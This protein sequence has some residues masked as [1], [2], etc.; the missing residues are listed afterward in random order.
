MKTTPNVCGCSAESQIDSI[1]PMNETTNPA[2]GV[3]PAQC[4]RHAKR[5]ASTTPRVVG[6]WMNFADLHREPFR[7]F[8]PAATLAGLIGIALWPIML[9]G[10]TGNYPGP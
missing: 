10:W 7:L 3:P 5:V 2:L 6:Q 8:F 4:P 9:L 1:S